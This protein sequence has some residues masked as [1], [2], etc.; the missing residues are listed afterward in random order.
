MLAKVPAFIFDNSGTFNASNG[1]F[2]TDTDFGDI[3]VK[4]LFKFIQIS[5]TRFFKGVHN[6]DIFRF[7]SLIAAILKQTYII[8]KVQFILISNSFI[9]HYAF[10][11][12]TKIDNI[13]TFSSD[14]V[15]FYRMGFFLPL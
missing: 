3:S 14:K 9:M 13:L 6:G 11:C 5:A 12:R 10:V 15:V 7:K 1:M 2:Y 8:R 4:P